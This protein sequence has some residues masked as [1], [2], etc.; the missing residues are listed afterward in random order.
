MNRTVLV[1]GATSGIGR[2]ICVDLLSEGH[3]V[4][5][6]GRDFSKFPCE[7]PNFSSVKLDLANLDRLPKRLKKLTAEYPDVDALVLN[8]GRGMFGGLEQYSFEQ[9]RELIDLNF[10]NHVFMVRA[11]LPEMKRRGF[12]DVVLMG[13]EAALAGRPYGSIYCASKAALRSFAQSLRAEAGPAGVRVTILNPGMVN[14]GF[15]D[16]LSFTPGP[17]E[18]NVIDPHD[19]AE[20]VALIL[21]LRRGT[22]VDEINLTPL[23]RVVAGRKGNGAK[24]GK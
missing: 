3:R 9:I 11:F 10:L 12:G 15:F 7:D 23:K 2:S 19:I 24:A 6:V 5:G 13:S 14:T 4:I 17:D 22:V 16:N 21:K 18:A 8:A 1:T 20:M